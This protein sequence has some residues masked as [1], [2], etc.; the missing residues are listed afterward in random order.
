MEALEGGLRGRVA[1]RRTRATVNALRFLAVC[2]EER[3]LMIK[4]FSPV[5]FSG[6]GGKETLWWRV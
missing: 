4:G 5:S 3:Q 2:Y 1:V 6:R